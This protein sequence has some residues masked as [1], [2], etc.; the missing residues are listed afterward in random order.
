MH[1]RG[2]YAVI[3]TALLLGALVCIAGGFAL[4]RWATFNDQEATAVRAIDDMSD[5]LLALPKAPC[6]HC[7]KMRGHP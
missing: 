5:A 6:P 7:G 2:G 4:G 3:T 1:A